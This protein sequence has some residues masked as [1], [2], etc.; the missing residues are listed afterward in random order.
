MFWNKKTDQN[1]LGVPLGDIQAMLAPTTIK[2][3]LKGNVLTARH[4]QYTV[5]IEVVS[6]A[7]RES[8]NGLIRAV[9]CMTTDLRAIGRAHWQVVGRVT[10]DYC[11]RATLS[12]KL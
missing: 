11:D 9:V 2:T 10:K 12:A 3:T 7:T 6:P 8:E 4:E 1:P 5:R